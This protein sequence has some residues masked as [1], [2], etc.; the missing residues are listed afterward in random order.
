[1]EKL[2]LSFNLILSSPFLRAKQTA[3]IVADELK[4]RKHLKFSDGLVPGGN[5]DVLIQALDELKP[6]PENILLVGHEPSLSQLISL[7]VFGDANA[8]VIQMKK[9]GLCKLQI[10]ELR[11]GQCA[12]LAWLLTPSQMELMA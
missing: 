2:E 10:G 4:L 1:M 11:H 8:A 9:G 12:R 6:A 7:L 3:E 5:P